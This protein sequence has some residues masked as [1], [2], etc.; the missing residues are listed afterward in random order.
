[1][2]RWKYAVPRLLLAAFVLLSIYVGLNP[3]VRW[4]LES[5]GEQVLS[6]R[7]EIGDLALS[8]HDTELKVS[9]LAVADPRNP[10]RNLVEA[11]EMKLALETGPLLERKF[12]VK[13]GLVRGLKFRVERQTEAEPV[14][15]WQLDLEGKRVEQLA[16]QWLETLALSMRE[17]VEEEINGLQSVRLAKE[18]LE[19]WPAEYQQLE[20]QVRGVKARVEA[21]RKLFQTPPANLTA[22]L[23]HYQTTLSELQRLQRDLGALGEQLDA[24]PNK[25]IADRGA[26]LAAKDHDIRT[27]RQRF[28]AI[29]LDE[30]ALT[31]YLLGPEMGKRVITLVDWVRWVRAHLPSEEEE[32]ENRLL[33]VDILFADKLERPDF[34]IESLLVDGQTEIAGRPYSFIATAAGV[35][36]DPKLYG[37]PAVI[38][39][40]LAGDTTVE[41]HAVLDRT[42]EAPA[43]QIVLNC[44]NIK[45]PGARLGREGVFCFELAPGNTHL[46]AGLTL[47]GDQVAGC[48]LLKQSGIVL[49]PS[50]AEPLG[51]AR[52][53]GSLAAASES[54]KEIEVQVDLSGA[55]VRPDLKI[56][57]NLGPKL[58]EGLNQ[59]ALSEIEHRRDQAAALVEQRVEQELTKFQ[60]R[61]LADEEILKSR[62][63]LSESEI[64]QLGKLVGQRVPSA[65]QI[66]SKALGGKTLP[67]R[68]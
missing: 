26:I 30:E 40:E 6:T 64:Q 53:A 67:L 50:V 61:L 45:L 16:E 60:N 21:V 19:R 51:G 48:M 58:A 23:Q 2:I 65:D 41:I 31:L 3:L 24:L 62:L 11:Q 33:G 18:L 47:R 56:R 7:V 44:P 12:V 20:A 15:H 5:F 22:G 57:S 17:K 35:T 43:D 46:W 49:T 52:L 13:D 10:K 55:I 27:L 4:G 63:K 8:L 37:R 14:D 25:A 36:T 54:L 9:R 39:A 66:L 68:F 59:L 34:L 32:P 1:M 42:G 28:E 38:R 29:R